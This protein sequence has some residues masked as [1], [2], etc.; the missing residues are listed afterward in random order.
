MPM[1]DDE[2]KYLNKSK[3]LMKCFTAGDRIYIKK[4]NNMKVSFIYKSTIFSY[5]HLKIM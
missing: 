5:P 4:L 1:S 2:K 3:G